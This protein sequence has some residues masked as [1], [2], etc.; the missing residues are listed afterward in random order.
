MH[1][2]TDDETGVVQPVIADREIGFLRAKQL[3]R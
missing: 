2:A 3:V 1:S